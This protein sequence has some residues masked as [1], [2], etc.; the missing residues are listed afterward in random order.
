[1]DM[2]ALTA[3]HLKARALNHE[4]HIKGFWKGLANYG[5]E[6][7]YKRQFR[8]MGIEFPDLSDN[9][10]LTKAISQFKDSAAGQCSSFYLLKKA[11]R[12]IPMLYSDISLLDY[13]CGCGKTLVMGMKLGFRN[14]YGVDL[15]KNAVILSGKNCSIMKAAGSQSDFSVIAQDATQFQVPQG[16]NLIYMFNPFGFRTMEKVIDNVEA[17]AKNCRGPLYIIYM[18]QQHENLLRDK[19][20][21][22][23]IFHSSFRNGRNP[24]MSIF[25][26]NAGFSH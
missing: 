8:K 19:P 23:R 6:F 2:S 16:V 11:F 21:F 13:G 12:H 5:H 26:V 4:I 20:G 17:Y 10:E 7:I 25:K 15:D 1:M 24:E 14:V 22:K 18:N 3:L 9:L